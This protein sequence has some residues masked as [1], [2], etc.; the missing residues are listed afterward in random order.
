MRKRGTITSVR[1]CVLV[2]MGL[3]LMSGVGGCRRVSSTSALVRV[4]YPQW[5]RD[6]RA[7]VFELEREHT[8]NYI[9]SWLFMAGPGGN[10]RTNVRELCVLD[11]DKAQIRRLGRG[12]RLQVI[13]GRPWVAC[14]TQRFTPAVKE[15]GLTIPEKA[16]LTLWLVNYDTGERRQV[17][18]DVSAYTASPDGRR[19]RVRSRGREYLYSLDEEFEPVDLAE[20]LARQTAIR[21][22][23]WRI[24][25][26]HD[27]RLLFY[28]TPEGGGQRAWFKYNFSSGAVEPIAPEDAP[29][30]DDIH[31]GERQLFN[32]DRR[33][34]KE[35]LPSPDGK[36]VLKVRR[37][38]SEYTRGL[39]WLTMTHLI[40]VKHKVR[41]ED[42]FL[43]APDGT[44]TQVTHFEE[45]DASAAAPDPPELQS[46]R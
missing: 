11:R 17:C 34:R 9:D 7:V 22:G 21:Q 27:G 24:R 41:V 44:E 19:M 4:H 14:E 6:S 42:L 5:R 31:D 2:V 35:G 3:A 28:V 43:V 30:K 26:A 36:A 29:G 40:P 18:D 12:R 1:G 15:P 20:R 38:E 39:M 8:E 37:S 16:V 32:D 33:S 45:S 10:K 25:W 13:P 46:D 23:Y